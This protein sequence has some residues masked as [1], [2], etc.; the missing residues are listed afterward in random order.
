MNEIN[1]ISLIHPDIYIH[2]LLPRGHQWIPPYYLQ[3][4][5]GS[6]R[7]IVVLPAVA[8]SVVTTKH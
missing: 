4:S 8:A 6:A 3:V 1:E 2:Q 5:I 7:Y